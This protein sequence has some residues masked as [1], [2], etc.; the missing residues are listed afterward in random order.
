M[1]DTRGEIAGSPRIV[2]EEVVCANRGNEGEEDSERLL[3]QCN[4]SPEVTVRSYW[5]LSYFQKPHGH[6]N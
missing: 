5:D 2:L 6:G 1:C 3:S 4:N